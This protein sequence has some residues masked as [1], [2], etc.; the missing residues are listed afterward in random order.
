MTVVIPG[1]RSFKNL[2]FT[3]F[4]PKGSNARSL[5]SILL[6]HTGSNMNVDP[7]YICQTLLKSF[8]RPTALALCSGNFYS[9]RNEYRFWK[10]L[11]DFSRHEAA[12]TLKLARVCCFCSG[13]CLKDSRLKSNRLKAALVLCCTNNFLTSCRF[14]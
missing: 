2:S 1:R 12:F 8:C 13:V 10:F 14:L 3:R 9:I 6:V 4:I 11:S 7:H 5:S